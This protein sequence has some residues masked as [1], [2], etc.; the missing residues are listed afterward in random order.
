MPL[1]GKYL[2]YSSEIT[3]EIF[4]LVWD[5]LSESYPPSY[6]D[7]IKT[8]F[9]EFKSGQY[10]SLNGKSVGIYSSK[11]IDNT[12]TTVREVLGY[13]PYIK[14]FVLPEKWCIK[15]SKEVG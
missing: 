12:E 15:H 9:E 4:T 3:L 5:K 1:T 8:R 11:H 2:K 10:I 6:P 7:D 13:D 14:E